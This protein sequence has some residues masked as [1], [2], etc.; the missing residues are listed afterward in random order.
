MEAWS[1]DSASAASS[2]FSTPFLFISRSDDSILLIQSLAGIMVKV[3]VM[4]RDS[5]EGKQTTYASCVC[6]V[7]IMTRCLGRV[8]NPN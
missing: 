6:A 7:Y 1:A 4:V 2:S 3:R 8:Q 5:D